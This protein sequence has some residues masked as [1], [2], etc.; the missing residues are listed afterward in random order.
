MADRSQLPMTT[1]PVPVVMERP[2][3]LVARGLEALQK[4]ETPRP[5]AVFDVI[6][7]YREAAERGDA[8]AQLK[9]GWEYH[10]G[11]VVPQDDEE[12]IRWWK[13]AAD[14]GCAAAQTSLGMAYTDFDHIPIDYVEA[15]K[16]FTLGRRSEPTDP[17]V[18]CTLPLNDQRDR[19]E[20]FM[21]KRNDISE[22]RFRVG[23]AY[24]TGD[25]VPQDGYTAYTA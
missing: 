2:G 23:D 24:L 10:T 3:N 1:A 20:T 22:A 6:A 9:L 5:V 21:D 4:T 7:D 13:K 25:G 8:E 17:N 18:T 16:W 11:K 19:I 14:Q 12:A 15:Y